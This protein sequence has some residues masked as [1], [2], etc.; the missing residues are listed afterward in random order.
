MV[1]M[2]GFNNDRRVMVLS[3]GDFVYIL[4]ENGKRLTHL[5][6]ACVL[7]K[8]LFEPDKFFVLLKSGHVY[9]LNEQM[10]EC[11]WT[12]DLTRTSAISNT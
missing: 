7:D 1:R 12:N 6:K 8:S 9:A 10:L 5:G 4:D 2:D 11:V 3:R